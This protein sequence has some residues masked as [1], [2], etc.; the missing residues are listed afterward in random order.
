MKRGRKTARRVWTALLALLLLF[1][2]G[3][4]P[5]RAEA[6]KKDLALEPGYYVRWKRGLP[7]RD[8]KWYRAM[9]IGDVTSGDFT[10]AFMRG[11]TFVPK[12][13]GGY[14]SSYIDGTVLGGDALLFAQDLNDV[15]IFS[16]SKNLVNI[17][18]FPDIDCDA[19][20]FYTASFM[21][22]PLLRYD[23]TGG[24]RKN[25][26]NPYYGNA[27][28]YSIKL[29]DW[30]EGDGKVQEQYLTY[31]PVNFKDTTG[32]DLLNFRVTTR[33][34][35]WYFCGNEHNNSISKNTYAI[36]NLAKDDNSATNSYLEFEALYDHSG[37]T[38]RTII[39]ASAGFTKWWFVRSFNIYYGEKVSIN[40]IRDNQE[41]TDGEVVSFTGDNLYTLAVG[42]TMTVKDG[43]VL[44]V[45]STFFNDGIIKVEK[46][47]TLIV[48]EGGSIMPWNTANA[49]GNIVC[50]G[51]DVIVFSGG[52]CVLN[53]SD[54]LRVKN[55]TVYNYGAI[56]TKNIDIRGLANSFH[57]YGAVMAGW[58]VQSDY[59]QK[60][61][62][63]DLSIANGT[64]SSSYLKNN[65]GGLY[66]VGG[67]VVTGTGF[68][69]N[70]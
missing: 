48:R 19:E 3:A 21:N 34:S 23:R 27:P 24:P 52:R 39:G 67:E 22:T 33:E 63:E 17:T 60:F 16:T 36:G 31:D 26:V 65:K 28:Y 61:R 46:G 57:N 38:T 10:T 70:Q 58:T 1:Q 56:L 9:I 15:N 49:W 59:A 66:A 55:G 12:T 69:Y 62:D 5:Q 35:S 29:S 64:L 4:F 11:N 54:G 50:D 7:P 43:G 6:K 68:S 32:S 14:S 42:S 51:G 2:S 13:Q 25:G 45:G 47:G 30:S 40:A 8:G 20:V 41:I 44:S 18:K 37:T 53:G